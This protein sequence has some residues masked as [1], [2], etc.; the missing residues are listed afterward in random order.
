MRDHLRVEPSRPVIISD[1]TGEFALLKA[2][3]DG[4]HA[5]TKTEERRKRQEW[6]FTNL[7]RTAAYMS[8]DQGWDD[9]QSEEI[10][11]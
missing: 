8:L 4:I 9:V 2:I 10:A 7:P 6:L 1:F 3:C 5:S 11:L